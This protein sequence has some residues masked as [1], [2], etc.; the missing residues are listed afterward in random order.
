MSQAALFP[1]ARYLRRSRNWPVQAGRQTSRSRPAPGGQAHSDGSGKDRLPVV[2]HADHR[3]AV[4]LGLVDQRLG[5]RADLGV[6]QAVRGAV[7][8][9]AL[10]VVV[11]HQHHQ[12]R[13]VAGAGPLE[14]LAVAVGVAERGVGPLADEQVDADRLAGLVV[15]EEQLGLAHQHRLAVLG[16]RTWSRC[17][18]RPPARAGRRRPARCRRARTRCRRR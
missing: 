1:L 18:S 7:G 10:G 15:D 13:A 8:V 3:P 4:L 16:S 6:R 2:L 5:E 14:H 12:P 17:S 9:L 11:E